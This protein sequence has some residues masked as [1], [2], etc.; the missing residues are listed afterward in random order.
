VDQPAVEPAGARGDRGQCAAKQ[1]TLRRLLE[2]V[3]MMTDQTKASDQHNEQIARTK[4]PE[5]ELLRQVSGVG[6]LIALR[7]VLTVDDLHRFA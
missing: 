2:Q 4:Y 7:F 5:T 3:E 6:P 1:Q